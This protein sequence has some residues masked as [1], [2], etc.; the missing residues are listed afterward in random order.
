MLTRL[1]LSFLV[2]L[3]ALLVVG[4]A[5]AGGAHPAQPVTHDHAA[6]PASRP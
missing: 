5:Q 4:A 1:Y 6:Q 3:L 2:A